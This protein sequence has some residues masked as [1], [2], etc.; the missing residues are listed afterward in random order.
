MLKRLW[1]SDEVVSLRA[2]LD[3]AVDGIGE[4]SGNYSLGL[5]LDASRILS[6]PFGAGVIYGSL[7]VMRV[8]SMFGVES[9]RYENYVN[10]YRR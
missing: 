9:D 8:C 5:V 6:V 4:Y 2:S 1:E 7:K 10:V 3:W